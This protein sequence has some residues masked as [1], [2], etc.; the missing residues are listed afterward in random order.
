[1][2]EKFKKDNIDSQRIE[3]ER[4][5]LKAQKRF[6]DSV[7]DLERRDLKNKKV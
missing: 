3:N 6:Q 1:M 2:N 5:E 7:M 4:T